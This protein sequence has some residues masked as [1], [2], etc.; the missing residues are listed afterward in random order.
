MDWRV[1]GEILKLAAVMVAAIT[2]GSWFLAEVKKAR[3]KNLPPYKAYFTLPGLLIIIAI[4]LP[5]IF[6]V[7]N[8]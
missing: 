6:W 5:L 2:L 8:R 7:I 1:L 3:N 4:V